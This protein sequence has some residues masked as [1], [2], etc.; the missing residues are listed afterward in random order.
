MCRHIVDVC[1][2]DPVN[3]DYEQLYEDDLDV[4]IIVIL[5][6]AR[7]QLRHGMWILTSFFVDI[8]HVRLVY[9][10]CKILLQD[11]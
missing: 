5:A 6:S 8:F 7:L 11:W 1:L 4:P 10:I 9:K 2:W 3:I